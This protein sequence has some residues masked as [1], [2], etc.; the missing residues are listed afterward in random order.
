MRPRAGPARAGLRP[1]PPKRTVGCY[2]PRSRT[3]HASGEY[4][5]FHEEAHAIQHA[6]LAPSWLLWRL[7]FV[8]P[9]LRHVATWWLERDAAGEALWQMTIRFQATSAIRAEASEHLANYRR[10]IGCP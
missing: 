4:A 9:W 6:T 10:R 3:I 1:H 2:F 8:L 5:Q 7:C